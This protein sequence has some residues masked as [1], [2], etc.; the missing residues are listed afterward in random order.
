MLIS[1]SLN[2]CH[3]DYASECVCESFS[4]LPSLLQHVEVV[5][6]GSDILGADASDLAEASDGELA[7]ADLMET[8]Q[9]HAAPVGH[10]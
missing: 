8:L 6:R 4:P 2:L 9:H 5:Q 7:V 3:H 10:V 1:A